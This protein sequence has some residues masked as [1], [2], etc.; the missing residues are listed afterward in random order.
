MWSDGECHGQK[1]VLMPRDSS[2]I[3]I[4][5]LS[6][7]LLLLV[8]EAGGLLAIFTLH[9]LRFLFLRGDL[10]EHAPPHVRRCP[11]RCAAG[12]SLGV[13]NVLWWNGPAVW[14]FVLI[15]R[16]GSC[17]LGNEVSAPTLAIC[18]V[19][20]GL[21]VSVRLPWSLSR[22]SLA[23]DMIDVSGIRRGQIEPSD[24]ESHL[25]CGQEMLTSSKGAEFSAGKSCSMI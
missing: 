7:T 17:F 8:L 20:H 11:V 18:V 23:T 10:L 5:R 12:Y 2:H 4:W 15:D 21:R 14:L 16:R 19:D 6:L 22:I 9:H 25:L 24:T 13:D 3:C 1:S